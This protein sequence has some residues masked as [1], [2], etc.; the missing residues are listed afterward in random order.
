MY[1]VGVFGFLFGLFDF[2]IL[3]CLFACY[4]YYCGLDGAAYLSWLRVLLVLV[5][6]FVVVLVVGVF[7][8]CFLFWLLL[9]C[10]LAMLV[11]DLA[12]VAFAVNSVVVIAFLLVW[13]IVVNY[14]FYVCCL[15]VLFPFGGLEVF[16]LACL[17]W[18][19]L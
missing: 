4:I 10:L 16:V 9:V 19:V 18:W 8:C 1:G 15:F 7:D 11:C 14:L 17:L 2:L 13:F 5:F 3:L 12:C 6:C